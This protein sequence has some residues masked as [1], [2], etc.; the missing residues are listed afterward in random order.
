MS[1]ILA[2]IAAKRYLLMHTCFPTSPLDLPATG[3]TWGSREFVSIVTMIILTGANMTCILCESNC[4]DIYCPI[5]QDA[6]N[7]V[8]S[9][10]EEQIDDNEVLIMGV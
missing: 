8:Q 2:L 6:I 3:P 10:V 7:E 9:G 1:R 5:C 4:T